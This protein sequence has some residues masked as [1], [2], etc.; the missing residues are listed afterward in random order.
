[1]VLK[2]FV[3]RIG[4]KL[5]IHPAADLKDERDHGIKEVGNIFLKGSFKP[6]EGRFI[7]DFI[8]KPAK[9]PYIWRKGEKNVKKTNCRYLKKVHNLKSCK[10]RG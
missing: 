3:R 10:Y 6:A 1:M 2:L 4:R 8:V 5:I 7:G 9:L